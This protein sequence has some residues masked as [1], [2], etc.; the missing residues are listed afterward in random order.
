M[1]YTINL[2]A[3]CDS[4]RNTKVIILSQIADDFA[5]LCA[6]LADEKVCSHCGKPHMTPISL[7][8]ENEEGDSYDII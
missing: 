1:N 6:D 7:Y 2:L 3:F 8:I 5:Q 4:C